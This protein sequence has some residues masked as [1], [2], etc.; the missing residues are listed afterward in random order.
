MGS[1]L[2][3]RWKWQ[4]WGS[5]SKLC[6]PGL[7]EAWQYPPG[8]KQLVQQSQYVAFCVSSICMHILKMHSSIA[9]QAQGRE[10]AFSFAQR[11][12]GGQEMAWQC[13]PLRRLSWL[14]VEEL[15]NS[16]LVTLVCW[17]TCSVCRL[18]LSDHPW[19]DCFR[20]LRD[21]FRP[22]R[23][24]ALEALKGLCAWQLADC[25]SPPVSCGFS[26]ATVAFAQ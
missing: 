6:R 17:E 7:N 15:R 10:S 16:S 19:L 4:W 26:L 5:K 14:Q 18:S 9:F 22:A 20:D 11:V 23:L 3:G 2:A 25:K 12:G 8:L 21:L 24:A 13:G 1:L